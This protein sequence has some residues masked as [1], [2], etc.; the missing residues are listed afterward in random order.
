MG[1]RF[2]RPGCPDTQINADA[3]A[4]YWLQTTGGDVTFIEATKGNGQ[5]IISLA[6]SDIDFVKMEVEMAFGTVI[7]DEDID[8]VVL[9][10]WINTF[11]SDNHRVALVRNIVFSIIFK[12]E[13]Y[14]NR[15]LTF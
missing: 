8:S 14:L 4:P 12:I 10:T 9:V 15:Y 3:I 2:I 7:E 13:R 6:R 11:H 1:D 5:S